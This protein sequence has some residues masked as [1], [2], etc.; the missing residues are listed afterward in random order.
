MHD[1]IHK[2]IKNL[3]GTAV[4]LHV[5]QEKI[6]LADHHQNIDASLLSLVKI[7]AKSHDCDVVAFGLVDNNYKTVALLHS[8]LLLD[9]VPKDCSSP[10][11]EDRKSHHLNNFKN[12]L[13]GKV[14]SLTNQSN[15]NNVEI[16]TDCFKR[17]AEPIFIKA[18]QKVVP[19]REGWRWL[20]SKIVRTNWYHEGVTKVVHDEED[21][22]FV[23]LSTMVLTPKNTTLKQRTFSQSSRVQTTTRS[24][25]GINWGS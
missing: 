8:N 14:L 15:I 7:V 3:L 9:L 20:P 16:M 10:T 24:T 23:M 18:D 2:K 22:A 4:A 12:D 25:S 17:A 11:W 13:V 19:V 6:K 21:I 5:N 1:K